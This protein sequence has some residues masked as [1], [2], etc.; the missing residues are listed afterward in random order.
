M[1]TDDEKKRNMVRLLNMTLLG[2][3]KGVWDFVGE[4]SF[5]LSQKIGNEILKMME[6]EMG[7]EIAG[8]NH[9]DV[10]NEICRLF[11]D[12][13]G[14]ARNIDVNEEDGV[15]T[16]NVQHCLNS[17]LND[18]LLEAGIE[19]SFICPI[20]NALVAAF[21]RMNIRARQDICKNPEGNGSIITLELM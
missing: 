18:Q 4:T 7:L 19:K 5:A 2:V 8:E 13:F 17:K 12:E 10:I 15:I 16:L 20:M 6:K 1:A 3:T 11:V 14:F 21:K 9:S